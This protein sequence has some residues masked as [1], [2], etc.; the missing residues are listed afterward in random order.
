[1]KNLIISSMKPVAALLFSI[2]ILLDALPSAEDATLHLFDKQ[3]LAP[4]E[5]A[6]IVIGTSVY[7]TASDGGVYLDIPADTFTIKAPGYKT[8]SVTLDDNR[9]ILL[10][11]F[12]IKALYL[13]SWAVGTAKYTRQVFKLIDETELN[14]VVIDVKNEYGHLT[15]PGNIKLART[16]GAYDKIRISDIDAFV[17]K[18]KQKGIYLIARMVVFKDDKLAG[19]MPELAIH[20]ENGDVWRNSEGIAWSDPF[21]Q[22]VR[23]YNIEIAADAARKGFDEI[24]FDYVRFP[25]ARRLRYREYNIQDNRVKA[26]NTFLKKAKEELDRL[27]VMI[28]VDTY[29]YVC[30]NENDT[31]IGHRLEDLGRYSDIISPMLYPSSY[32]LGIPG[33]EDSLNHIYRLIHDSLQ[34]GYRRTGIAK[35]RFRPWLQA[36]PDYAFD[37][38]QFRGEEIREQIDAAEDFNTG[39]WMLW[40]PGSYFRHYGLKTAKEGVTPQ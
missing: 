21:I 38:R 19:R 26:V 34:E 8:A 4:V 20:D 36:F 12:N 5:G 35:R 6:K 3:S 9:T 17:K 31:G 22:K 23:D 29:G 25:D 33:Y 27:G 10:E 14:A 16:I 28:S 7:T 15:Y 39:G 2:T 40:H 37:H 18:L 11:P 32:H 1:M 24:N 30:W 13:S